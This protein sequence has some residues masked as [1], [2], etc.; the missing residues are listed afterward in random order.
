MK[1][2][3]LELTNFGGVKKFAVDFGKL[4]ILTGRNAEGKTRVLRGA[5]IGLIGY[6][7]ALG[8]TK[9]A[10]LASGNL[11]VK[12]FLQDA[13]KVLI[14]EWNWKRTKTG[15]SA[16]GQQPAPVEI[17]ST[18]LDFRTFLN[19]TGPQQIAFVI[20]QTDLNAIGFSLDKLKAEIKS[21]VPEQPTEQTEKAMQ[22]IIADIYKA[23]E[24]AKAASMN[25]AGWLELLFSKL[26]DRA[27]LAKQELDRLTGSI[28]TGVALNAEGSSRQKIAIDRDIEAVNQ[29]ITKLS[30]D[31]QVMREQWNDSKKTQDRIA[32]ISKRLE[33]QPNS[34]EELAKLTERAAFLSKE[35]NAYVEDFGVI[36]TEYQKALKA[37][38]GAQALVSQVEN[39][40]NR[41]RLDIAVI[42]ASAPCPCCGMAKLGCA[43]NRRRHSELT[44]QLEQLEADLLTAQA[45][46]QQ[47]DQVAE[48]AK[49]ANRA[50]LAA[51]EKNRSQQS[52]FNDVNAKIARIK[53]GEAAF[54]KL[55]GE[56][57]ALSSRPNLPAATEQALLTYDADIEAA[58]VEL[59]FLNGEL[60]TATAA[61]AAQLRRVQEEESQEQARA[62][63]EVAK[64][65]L[66]KVTQEKERLVSESM[67]NLLKVARRFTDGIVTG[68]LSWENDE[69][70]IRRGEYWVSHEVFSGTEAAI[71]YIGVAVALCQSSKFKLVLMDELGVVDDANIM[72]LLAKIEALIEA[73]VVDQFIACD[74]RHERYANLASENLNV[75]KI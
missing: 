27:K 23:D 31:S 9:T 13:G 49:E 29:R 51:Y 20:E 64:L 47:A 52:E 72:V 30:S 67:K 50:A 62:N 68:E 55:R 8:K 11:G 16:V 18:L 42:D 25:A 61:A 36:T 22:E 75:I 10:K 3:H 69:I 40:I 12:I 60:A 7:P 43:A 28:Q 6:D 32:E 46:E 19:K 70:G 39:S 38:S 1:I 41:Y 71:A 73:G 24:E 33:A 63:Y 54:E 59:R 66:D 37:H 15:L 58:K 26:K 2:Q 4:N 17:A 44:S 65:A 56:L 48:T 53:E 21:V 74:V 14:N 34:A 35:L 57:E 5:K 45:G